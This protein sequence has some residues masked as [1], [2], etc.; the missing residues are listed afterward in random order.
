MWCF[1]FGLPESSWYSQSQNL[2]SNIMVLCVPFNLFKSYLQDCTQYTELSNTSSQILPINNGVP[3]GSVLGPLLF[4]IYVNDLHNV[5]QYSDIHHFADDTN[6]LYS[7]K[8]L[9]DIKVNF[10]LKNIVHWLRANI[11]KYK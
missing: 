8:S 2:T 6:L 4:L 10:E 1:F 9:K 5:V 3:Q 7:S 11:F